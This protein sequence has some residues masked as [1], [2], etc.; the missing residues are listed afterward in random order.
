MIL[1]TAAVSQFE[2]QGFISVPRLAPAAELEMLRSVFERLFARRAGRKEGMQYDMLG[3]DED[4]A[5][6]ALPTII[7]PSNYD[8]ALRRLQCRDNA[9]AIARRLLGAHAVRSFEQVILKPA[10]HGGATPWHQDEAHRADPGFAYHQVSIWMPLLDAT[11]DNGCMLY[12]PGSHREGVLPHRSPGGDRKVH[13]IECTE[14]F[15]M[16]AAVAC[17]VAAG[18]ATVHHGR[19]VHSAGP[20]RTSIPRY[21]LIFS[22]ELPPQPLASARNFHWS[23]EN[24]A[25]NRRRR[26]LWRLRGGI[27][28]EAVRKLRTGMWRH[29]SRLL[30][31]ARR[32][33]RALT[34]KS[35]RSK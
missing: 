6:P 26:R 33:W 16:S 22:F 31:E 25:S 8:R 3:H 20:N 28:I 19:T 5:E 30:F 2:V 32:A 11:Q 7:N 35:L 34:R 4:D 13:S 17:P 23:V 24:E 14:G 1:P 12:I 29:P 10:L 9:A 21:A 27:V 18:H 15:N